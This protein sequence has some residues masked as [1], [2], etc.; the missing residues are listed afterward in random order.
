MTLWACISN[1][2]VECFHRLHISGICSV[3]CITLTALIA[4]ATS[5]KKEKSKAS[6]FFKLSIVLSLKEMAIR[7]T[8]E[9]NKICA[10]QS[11]TIQL[12]NVDFILL[13]SVYILSYKVHV[14]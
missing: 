4:Y 6:P 3:I 8:C 14:I 1:R 5:D 13:Q 10:F 11:A 7:V 9:N 2:L 12:E